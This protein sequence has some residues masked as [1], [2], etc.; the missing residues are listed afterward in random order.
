MNT[1][2][3]EGAGFRHLHLHPHACGRGRVGI[4]ASGC[5]GLGVVR[6]ATATNADCTEE[7]DGQYQSTP[8]DTHALLF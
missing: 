6:V 5:A 1:S 7:A 4:D 3:R 2:S 8:A